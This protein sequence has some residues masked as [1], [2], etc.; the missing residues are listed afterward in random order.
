M[1]TM[2]AN[3][4]GVKLLATLGESP[5]V[6]KCIICQRSTDDATISTYSNGRKHIRDAAEIRQ[7]SV[8]KLLENLTTMM[9]ISYIT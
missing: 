5:D 7:D 8:A 9:S 1:I 3:T 2:E 6:K 4:S